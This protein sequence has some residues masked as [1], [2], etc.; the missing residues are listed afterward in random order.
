[1]GHP[2]RSVHKCV[3]GPMTVVP[4]P[5]WDGFSLVTLCPCGPV[6]GHG[7]VAPEEAWSCPGEPPSP[8]EFPQQP[9]ALGPHTPGKSRCAR[10]FEAGAH[11]PLPL[12]GLQGSP[13]RLQRRE[14]QPLGAV[15]R[16]PWVRETRGEPG[17]SL[18]LKGGGSGP[19]RPPPSLHNLPTGPAPTVRP[20]PGRRALAEWGISPSHR[21][22]ASSTLSPTP[23]VLLPIGPSSRTTS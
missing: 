7:P 17:G 5:P 21:C 2:G 19:H 1:M 16:R 22:L 18:A 4:Q 13:P 9:P 11:P 8:P 3:N 10:P 20:T 12:P 6:T 14:K 15:G 23:R